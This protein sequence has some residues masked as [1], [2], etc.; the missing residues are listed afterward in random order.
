[1]TADPDG[2]STMQARPGTAD[3]LRRAWRMTLPP[4]VEAARLAR[5]ATRD[6][7][8]SWNVGY[9]EETATLLVS[10]LVSNALR[11]AW[12]G[13]L[14][15][16]LRL[17]VTETWLRIEV[18]DSDPRPPEPRTPAD[19]DESGFGFVLVEALADKWGVR[20]TTTGKAVCVELDIC[21]YAPGESAGMR[22]AAEMAEQ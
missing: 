13:N 17:E 8:A 9:L 6:T 4:V 16:E 19:L 7:L 12:H 2:S 5:R 15:Q 1:M 3:E 21:G 18:L 22:A 20:P 14:A 10:E 11:H